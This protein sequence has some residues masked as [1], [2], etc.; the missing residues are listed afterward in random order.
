MIVWFLNEQENTTYLSFAGNYQMNSK[1]DLDARWT[2]TNNTG[3]YIFS[4]YNN[5][6]PLTAAGVPVSQTIQQDGAR[7]TVAVYQ[8]TQ[9]LPNTMYWK[10][11]YNFGLTYH[12][13]ETWSLRG[14]WM[15]L[16]FIT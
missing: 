14:N 5:Q 3:D 13:N 1:V 8:P 11:D 9:S 7:M 12:I 2:L 4:G 16:R 15:L 6:F 10:E